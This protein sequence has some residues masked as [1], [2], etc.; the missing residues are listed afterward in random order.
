MTDYKDRV[1]RAHAEMENLRE[2]TKRQSEADRKFAVQKLLVD[3]LEVADN[4]GRALGALPPPVRAAAE[5]GEQPEGADATMTA[6]HQLAVGL[7][8]TDKALA[9]AL[10]KHGAQKCVP[11]GEPYNANTMEAAFKVPNTGKEK[12]SVVHVQT[13]GYTL[14]DRVIRAAVVGIA[15]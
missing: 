15:E 10:G 11:L 3:L 4:L 8:M 12:G 13:P 7:S 9:K 5:A 6:L 14:N 2:R 1:L